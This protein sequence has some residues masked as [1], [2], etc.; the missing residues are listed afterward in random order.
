MFF[1]AAKS[2]ISP[3]AAYISK[4]VNIRLSLEF[5]KTYSNIRERNYPGYE[6]KNLL[7]GKKLETLES[8]YFTE[9]CCDRN[10]WI[11]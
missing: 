8:I 10:L 5:L 11:G 6:K 9:L 1:L 3:Q 4:K 2:Y 7:E